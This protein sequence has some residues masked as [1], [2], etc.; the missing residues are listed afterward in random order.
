M[1]RRRLGRRTHLRKEIKASPAPIWSRSSHVARTKGTTT[2]LTRPIPSRRRRTRLWKKC[3]ACGKLGHFSKKFPDQTD[4]RAKKANES[5]DVNMVAMGNTGDRYGNLPT[6]LSV[7]QST[8]W[9][10]DTGAN[11]HYVLA[12]PCFLLTRL[13]GTPLC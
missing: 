10:L 3:Y 4:H 5:K 8:S 13:F 6:V 2:S 7:F 1:L 12:S 11:V 9:W